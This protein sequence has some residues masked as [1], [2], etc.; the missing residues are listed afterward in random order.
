[1]K[2]HHEV[3]LTDPSAAALGEYKAKPALRWSSSAGALR[4]RGRIQ[5]KIELI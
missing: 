3:N 4:T 1:V 5:S 2:G